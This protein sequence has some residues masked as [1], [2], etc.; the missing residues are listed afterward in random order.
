MA[1]LIHRYAGSRK[2]T[3]GY[4][5][6]INMSKKIDIVPLK[7]TDLMDTLPLELIATIAD[8]LS[9]RDAFRLGTTCWLYYDLT[10]GLCAHRVR[11]DWLA[12]RARMQSTFKAIADGYYA[13]INDDVGVRSF[14]VIDQQFFMYFLD[15]HINHTVRMR[16]CALAPRRYIY[17]MTW[18]LHKRDDG[19]YHLKYHAACLGPEPA[20]PSRCVNFSEFAQNVVVLNGGN[21]PERY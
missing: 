15:R 2:P 8:G 7:I 16:P 13:I 5:F 3:I 12:H 21:Q 14:K 20:R 9:I 19:G 11:R 18:Q 17:S 1:L 10:R 4:F 6:D